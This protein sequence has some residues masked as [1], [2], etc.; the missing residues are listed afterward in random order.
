MQ[1]VGFDPGSDFIVQRLVENKYKIKEP[2]AHDEIFLGYP[3]TPEMVDYEVLRLWKVYGY[4]FK[5]IGR[6]KKN[7]TALDFSL[8]VPL[9]GVYI[10]A[11]TAAENAGLK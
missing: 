3:M 6:L 2:F 9:S 1:I 11:K 8:F 5:V 4:N 10:M 7:G